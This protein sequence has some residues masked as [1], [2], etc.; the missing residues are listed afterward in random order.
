ME[1]GLGTVQFG[2]DYGIGND[3]GKTPFGEVAEI[4]KAAAAGG[5]EWLDTGAMYGDAEEVLGQALHGWQNGFR[6]VTKTPHFSSASLTED[7]AERLESS[8]MSSLRKLGRFP[9]PSASLPWHLAQLP[10]KSFLPPAIASAS[11]V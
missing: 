6:I 5:V 8:L 2:L 3:R 10:S 1:L 7:D 9:I 4:L 11:P